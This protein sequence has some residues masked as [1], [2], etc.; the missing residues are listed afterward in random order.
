MKKK[1]SSTAAAALTALTAPAAVTVAASAPASAA[2]V[3]IKAE[4]AQVYL[5]DWTFRQKESRSDYRSGSA[6]PEPCA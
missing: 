4:R 5:G 1:A 2:A 3:T 6:G